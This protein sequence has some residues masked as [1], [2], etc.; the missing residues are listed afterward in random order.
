MKTILGRLSAAL[1]MPGISKEF[2]NNIDL[3]AVEKSEVDID[4][5]NFFCS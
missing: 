1:T 4:I 5:F 3:L 2:I